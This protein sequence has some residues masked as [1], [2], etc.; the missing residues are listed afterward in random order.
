MHARIFGTGRIREATVIRNN[1]VLYTVRP[2]EQDVEF[3]FTDQEPVF[4]T[5]WYQLQAILENGEI[6]WS[7]PIG[8]H[9]Q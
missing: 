1:E 8:V 2:M 6:A 4:G 5:S 9:R 7:S 3:H